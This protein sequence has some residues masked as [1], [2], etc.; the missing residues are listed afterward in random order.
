MPNGAQKPLWI[1]VPAGTKPQACR[2][3]EFGGSCCK[4]IYF[5]VNPRT[6]RPTPV[7]CDVPGGKHP[8]EA[9][10][11]RQR[12]LFAGD[13][14]VRDGRGVSHFDTCP[15]AQRFRE[16]AREREAARA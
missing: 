9:K 13:V 15:D 3:M 2:G 6:G 7:D 10:D 12:D 4:Q 14:E 1:T 16:R 5:S 8:S 11:K